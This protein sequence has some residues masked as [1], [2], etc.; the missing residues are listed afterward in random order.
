MP[1]LPDRP[2]RERR[3][4]EAVLLILMM[5][6]GHRNSLLADA[7]SSRLAETIAPELEDTYVTAARR[8]ARQAGITLDESTLASSA[9]EWAS[10][11][12]TTLAGS[13]GD[14]TRAGLRDAETA[15]AAG[16]GTIEELSDP[17]FSEARAA[18][19]GVTET[20]RAVTA[21]ERSV[22]S[23]VAGLGIELSNATWHAS[24]LSNM[25]EDC[26]ALD[27]ASSDEWMLECPGGPPKH[28]NCNCWLDYEFSADGE[29][30]DE[31]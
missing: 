2:A 14:T 19:I 5:Q 10:G 28:P 23:M 31:I 24:G 11:Y 13:I 21:G 22:V 26:L 25:C 30:E 18:N 4:A 6:A 20:T 1:D 9:S 12:S 29:P 3:L 17:L 16:E 27:G 7:Y 15:A 8:L